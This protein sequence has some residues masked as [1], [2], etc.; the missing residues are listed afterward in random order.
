MGTNLS[1]NAAI[2]RTNAAI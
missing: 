1:T 2:R